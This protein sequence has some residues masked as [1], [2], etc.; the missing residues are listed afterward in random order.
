MNLPSVHGCALLAAALVLV[1]TTAAQ[2]PPAPAP[3]PAPKQSDI[4][5]CKEMTKTASG[6]EIGFLKKGKDGPGPR[7]DDTVEV[8]YTGWL[9]DGTK[10]DSSRDRGQPATFGVTQVIKGWTEGLQLMTEGARCKLVI[11]GNLAYGEGGSPP[12][13]PANATLVFDVELLKVVRM[14][15]LRPATPD[16]QKTLADSGI[17]YEIVQEGKGDAVGDADGIAMRYAFW[18]T[19]GELLDCSERQNN[20]RISGTL[21]TLPLP[22]LADLAKLCKVGTIL[23]AELPQK[24]FPNAQADTVWELELT[25][26]N[27]LPS[28]RELA[29]DKTV[30]TQSG[31]QY[32]VIA[33]GE[34]ASPGAADEVVVHYSGWLTDGT[35]FDSSHARGQTISFT[36]NRVIKGWTEG[37]QLMKPGG[38]F[39][40]S[41]PGDLAYGARGSPPKIPANATLVFLVELVEVKKK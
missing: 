11:P 6:L 28:F 8:H 23:R 32:E 12:K 4:P 33:A 25:A 35:L 14:P 1:A 21:T 37:V 5:E 20:S 38:K 30:T 24:L 26:I 41:I 2:D 34:G 16:A 13:I 40:F 17:K 19:N 27:K 3:A 18:K 10:F 9:T 22:F 36:L 31:L 39:L 15:A 29:K 7:P